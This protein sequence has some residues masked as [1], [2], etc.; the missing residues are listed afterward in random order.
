MQALAS[1]RKPRKLENAD[2][3]FLFVN[4]YV[5]AV[6][7]AALAWRAIKASVLGLDIEHVA[8][9]VAKV[10]VHATSLRGG[11]PT[12]DSGADRDQDAV[13]RITGGAGCED[14]QALGETQGR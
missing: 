8:V 13:L 3:A 7:F 10:S 12:V 6:L 11:L 2:D 14:R 4:A 1:L 9:H 5:K